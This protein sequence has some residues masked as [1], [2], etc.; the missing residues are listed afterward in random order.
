MLTLQWDVLIPDTIPHGY[1]VGIDIGLTN[2]VATSNGLLTGKELRK[3]SLCCMNTLQT[4]EKIGIASYHIKSA[5]T[6]RWRFSK[7]L[8]WSDCQGRC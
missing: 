8:I 3:K 5:M 4:A 2:F 6:Q 7:T 1:P